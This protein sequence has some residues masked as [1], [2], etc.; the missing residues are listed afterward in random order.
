MTRLRSE[1][2]TIPDHVLFRELDGEA[3]LLD[4]EGEMY[5]GLDEVGTRVW[6]GLSDSGTAEAA[7]E[8]VLQEFDVSREVL[9][10]DVATLLEELVSRGLIEPV[11]R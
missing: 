8:A 6:H 5:F 1:H 3:V 4:L 10:R 11:S 2:Y 9:E 7:L